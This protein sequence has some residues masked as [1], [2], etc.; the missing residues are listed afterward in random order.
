MQAKTTHPSFIRAAMA[1]FGLQP[2]QTLGSFAREL[3]D[4]D[5]SDRRDIAETLEAEGVTF[6]G[7]F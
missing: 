5:Y 1:F 6:A 2:G 4:M 7:P 3:M